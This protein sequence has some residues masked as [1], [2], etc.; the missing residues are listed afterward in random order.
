MVTDGR[1]GSRLG[2]RSAGLALSL[3]A[4][5]STG[6]ACG[7][8]DP[9]AVSAQG[10]SI[11]VA[12]AASLRDAFEQLGG[13]LETAQGI[14]VTFSFDSS[15]S[16]ATQ[17][18]EGAP[19]DLYASAAASDM[20][21]LADEGLVDAPEVFARNRLTIVTEP[22]NPRDVGSLADLVDAGII[23]LCGADVPCGRYAQLALDAAGVAIPEHRVSRGQSATATLTAVAEGDAVAGIVYVSDAL[24]AGSAVESVQI[25]DDDVTA[26]YVIGVL[27]RTDHADSARAFVDLVL[28]DAGQAVLEDHGF[29]PAP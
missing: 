10:A 24:S 19:A 25:R 15:S 2:R 6:F 22:G 17:I 12:A 5:L 11:T 18:V 14:E 9:D 27:D 21:R 26:R 8:D 29:L 28:S 16:L 23:S 7:G 3:L 4:L 13:Q 20:D 1:R